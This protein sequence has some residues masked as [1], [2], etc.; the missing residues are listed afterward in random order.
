MTVTFFGSV[1]EYTSGDKTFSSADARSLRIL[2]E[3][4]GEH[5]G[6]RFKAFLTGDDACIFLVNGKSI[7]MTGGLD[8]PLGSDDTV[9]VLPFVPGG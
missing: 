1:Q 6:D 7:A 3:Q 8:T 2:I 9:D 4:L 5:Y